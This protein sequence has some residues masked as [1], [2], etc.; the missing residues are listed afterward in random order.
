MKE[1]HTWSLQDPRGGQHT[2]D[3][4]ATAIMLPLSCLCE[5]FL[6]SRLGAQVQKSPK[7]WARQG[8]LA[9]ASGCNVKLL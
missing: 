7:W 2:K 9:V 5:H 6:F 8:T 1:T 4:L 3:L